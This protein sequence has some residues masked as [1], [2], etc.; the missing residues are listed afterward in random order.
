MG[1]QAEQAF[2]VQNTGFAN[3]VVSGLT[4]TG[5]GYTA[6][7]DTFSLT[8]AQSQQVTVTFIPQ[9]DSVYMGELIIT[10]N[11]TSSPDTIGLSGTG[12]VPEPVYSPDA[13][14]YGNVQ[15]GQQVDLGF[16]VQNTGEG[17]LNVAD[18]SATSSDFTISSK[19]LQ[20]DPG[21]DTTITVTFASSEFRSYSEHLTSCGAKVTVTS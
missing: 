13:L 18:I 20:V 8:R 5:D 16:Q 3:L 14:Q 4:L 7:P 11:G 17:V 21:Q 19:I 6:A 15:V 9:R 1:E 12:L 10:H 2:S